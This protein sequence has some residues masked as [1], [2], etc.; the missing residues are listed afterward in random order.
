[1]AARSLW[2]GSISLGVVSIPVRLLAA[3]E[4]KELRFHFVEKHDSIGRRRAARS[5]T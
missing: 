4:S 1:M 5:S 3:T 2:T